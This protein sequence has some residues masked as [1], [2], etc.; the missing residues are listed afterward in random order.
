M[1]TPVTLKSSDNTVM[2]CRL[3]FDLDKSRRKKRNSRKEPFKSSKVQKF[4]RIMCGGYNLTKF[5]NFLGIVLRAQIVT[6][7]GS[8]MVTVSTR[9]TTMLLGGSFQEFRFYCLDQKV[10][11]NAN[12]PITHFGS[13]LFVREKV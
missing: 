2:H 10:V 12:C 9:N 3:I 13:F 4:G 1:P 5:A 11:Y 6:N 8:K 7:F